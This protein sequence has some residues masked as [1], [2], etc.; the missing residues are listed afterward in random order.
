VRRLGVLGEDVYVLSL[1]NMHIGYGTVCALA[2][3]AQTDT[4]HRDSNWVQ[5]E[6]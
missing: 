4:V 5:I 6:R 3:L 1:Y 2:F